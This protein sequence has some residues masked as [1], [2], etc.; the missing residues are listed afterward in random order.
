[1]LKLIGD[2]V[3]GN[4]GSEQRF[5]YTCLGDAVNL[6]SR[7]EG[8]SKNYGVLIV[9]G[10][11]TAERVEGEY[12]TLELDC[13]AVKGKT[14]G[15]TIYTVFYNP[16]YNIERW[17]SAREQHNAMLL[18]YRQQNWDTAILAV[19]QLRGQFAG[20]MD[21]YYDLWLE[22]IEEMRNAGLPKDWDGI[23]RAQSK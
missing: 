10:T 4:M 12:F 21:Q 8:Q 11:I 2:V 1:M 15:V 3:V 9:L 20:Q 13:I 6:A 22:R 14:E 23:F 7:L 16:E 19:T 18:A 5:D 17:Y